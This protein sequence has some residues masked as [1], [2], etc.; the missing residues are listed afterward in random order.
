MMRYF[1]ALFLTVMIEAGV[2][3]SLT[4]SPHRGRRILESAA[5]NLFTHPIAF[6]VWDGSSLGFW[7]I[8]A[9]VIVVEALLYRF[10]S[11]TDTKTAWLLSVCANGPTLALSFVL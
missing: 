10:V 1:T 8:E 2:V 5:I 7:T 3:A 4:K 6:A 11:R 9:A